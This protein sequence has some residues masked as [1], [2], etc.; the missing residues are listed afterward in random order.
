MKIY[1]S[2]PMIAN[3]TLSRANILAKAIRDSG[4]EVASPWVLGP[5]EKDSVAVNVFQRDRLGVEN[6]DATLA[7]VSQPSTG[8]GMEI[9]AAYKARKRIILVAKKGSIL[10]R[11]LLHMEGKELV[12]FEDDEDLYEKVL[13]QLK[14]SPGMAG[15]PGSSQ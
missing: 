3:R 12:E 9:M 5:V 13:K 11:M 10:S 8:V 7:D 6:S 4:H 2:V 1:L 14:T 15:R